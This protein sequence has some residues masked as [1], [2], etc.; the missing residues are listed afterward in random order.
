MALRVWL[1]CEI[2]AL[3]NTFFQWGW[4]GSPSCSDCFEQIKSGFWRMHFQREESRSVVALCTE[5]LVHRGSLGFLFC[6]K[7]NLSFFW[8]LPSVSAAREGTCEVQW[9]IRTP[10]EDGHNS[11]PRANLPPRA[12]R[13]PQ[14]HFLHYIRC[15][16]LLKR[17]LRAFINFLCCVL[18]FCSFILAA[19]SH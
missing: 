9:P 19:F 2:Q 1:K 4:S 3:E 7:S 16:G 6:V 10:A 14:I 13:Q 17:R 18:Y 15:L 5:R 11:S 8:P 12:G